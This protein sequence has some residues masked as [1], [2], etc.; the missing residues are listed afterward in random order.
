MEIV[1]ILLG[2]IIILALIA[3]YF[4]YKASSAKDDSRI[5]DLKYQIESIKSEIP[6]LDNT[7]KS[8]ISTNRSES[9]TA[10]KDI[11]STL[12]RAGL[13]SHSLQTFKI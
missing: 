11:A 9:S 6:K 12:A 3:I 10:Q 5:N 8:E 1:Y 4:A 13:W 7:I 2:L